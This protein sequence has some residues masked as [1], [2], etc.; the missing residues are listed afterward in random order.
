MSNL[1]LVN[2]SPKIVPIHKRLRNGQWYTIYNC[3]FRAVEYPEGITI[4]DVPYNVN[5]H[6]D[7]Y[8]DKL[9]V[10]EYLAMLKAIPTPCVIVHYPEATINLLPKVW[11]HCDKAVA[12]VYNANTPRQHRSISWWGCKPD[13]RC[14]GQPYQNLNDKRIK[15]RMARGEMARLYD[16]WEIQQIKNTSAEKVKG[17]V[18]H[19]CQTPEEVVRRIIATTVPKGMT[20][21][22]PFMGSGTTGAVAIEMGYNFIGFELDPVYFQMAANRIKQAVPSS[23]QPGSGF[24]MNQKA[25]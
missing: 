2:K 1:R 20:V 24:W 12:W 11:G 8:K 17:E 22:D 5:F 23:E 19:P 21:I 7:T 16:W 15:E 10:E 9:K 14:Y 3:D 18:I 25:A 4:S 6:Y 13:L